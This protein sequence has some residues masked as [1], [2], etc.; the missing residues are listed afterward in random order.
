MLCSGRRIHDLT[1][2]RVD[3]NHCIRSD[4]SVIFWPQFGSKTD[5]SNHRQSGWK[6][7]SN[8]NNRKL[9][10]VFWLEKTI[11]MLN[12]R[13]NTA[14]TFNLFI[15]LRGVAKPASRTVIAGWIRTI[16][17]EAEIKATPGSTRSAVASKSWLENH[18]IEE[19]LTRGNWRSV[20]TFKNFYK[21]ELME[22][23]N[24]NNVTQLFNPVN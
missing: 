5:C 8:I 7:L 4:D 23:N 13:R 15:T 2:L 3:D 16:F 11:V 17:K 18:P 22:T 6:L 20:N 10:P 19:I 1:L 9:D 21:R 24:S 12:E 14:N